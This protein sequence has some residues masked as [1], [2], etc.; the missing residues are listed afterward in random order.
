LT[1]PTGIVSL[2]RRLEISGEAR[3]KHQIGTRKGKLPAQLLTDGD[4]GDH[5][6][7]LRCSKRILEIGERQ[8]LDLALVGDLQLG[9]DFAGNIHIEARKLSV[10][11]HE[12]ERGKIDRR[13][14]A[15]AHQRRQIRLGQPLSGIEQQRQG[16]RRLLRQQRERA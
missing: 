6:V 14:E 16:R 2:E 9:T 8:R 11:V 13:Q 7:P 4:A 12:I 5:R 3:G 15:K 10:L 1:T